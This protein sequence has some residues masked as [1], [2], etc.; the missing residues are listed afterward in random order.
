[1]AKR[2]PDLI[3]RDLQ[4][5]NRRARDASALYA[6][7]TDERSALIVEASDRGLARSTIARHLNI[8]ANRVQQI[9]DRAIAKRSRED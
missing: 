7:A 5:A 4:L 8:S 6:K 9:L 1:V 2:D 3:L